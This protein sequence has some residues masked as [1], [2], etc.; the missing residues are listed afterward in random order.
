[1]IS[2][3]LLSFCPVALIISIEAIVPCEGEALVILGKES[4]VATV[5]I[6]WRKRRLGEEVPSRNK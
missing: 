6:V 5:E 2:S 4:M 1:M 3:S